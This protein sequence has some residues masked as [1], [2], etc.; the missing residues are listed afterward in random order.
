MPARTRILPTSPSFTYAPLPTTT[1]PATQLT[2]HS[3]QVRTRSRA[4]ARSASRSAI[5][6]CRSVRLSSARSRCACSFIDTPTFAPTG[7]DE[8]RDSGPVRT[9]QAPGL[10]LGVASS[11]VAP[12]R[13][14]SDPPVLHIAS[15]KR[16]LHVTRY[17]HTTAVGRH[18][19]QCFADE[20]S[21]QWRETSK[22]SSSSARSGK[23]GLQGE[24]GGD[25]RTSQLA[26]RDKSRDRFILRDLSGACA[27]ISSRSTTRHMSA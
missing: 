26:S 22:H 21:V 9:I 16:H 10:L 6:R 8:F 18:R 2:R 25:F 3:R 17:H 27:P 4:R 12:A 5:A 11:R 1:R 23:A 20:A 13:A 15:R 19:T 14:P 24:C 7:R